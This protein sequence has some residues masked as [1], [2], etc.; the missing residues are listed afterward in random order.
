MKQKQRLKNY[1]NKFNH[2]I[3]N[4]A[5]NKFWRK[6]NIFHKLCQENL[7]PTCGK[8]K[9][10]MY[11][12]HCTKTNSKYIKDPNTKPE[13]PKPI[14]QENI[15]SALHNIGRKRISK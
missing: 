6:E 14:L 10:N 8:M 1:Y 4:I 9:L 7:I 12:L 15:S 11:Q 3:L 5:D 2:L 13:T